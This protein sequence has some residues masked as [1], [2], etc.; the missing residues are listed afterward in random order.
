MDVILHPRSEEPLY[1]QLYRQI[2][3]Q[4]ASGDLSPGEMLPSIRTAARYLNVAVITVKTAYEELEKEGYITAVPA[5]GCFVSVNAPALVDRSKMDVDKAYETFLDVCKKSGLS[6][7]EI[8][9]LVTEKIR[10]KKC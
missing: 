3:S 10:R 1:K 6:D 7:E 9:T 5:K 2:L 8:V 4:I